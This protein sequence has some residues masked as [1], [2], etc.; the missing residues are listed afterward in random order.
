ML[1][2]ERHPRE[3]YVDIWRKIEREGSWQGEIWDKRKNGEVYPKWL[4]ISSVKGKDGEVTHY[5]GSFTD[6]TAYKEAQDEVVSLAFTTSSPNS[7]TA[8]CCWTGWDTPWR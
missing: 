7:P 1:K 5:V 3:F 4:S 8:A 2:S 6:I